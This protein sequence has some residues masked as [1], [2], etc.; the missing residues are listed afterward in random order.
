MKRAEKN[1]KKAARG[2][3]PCTQLSIH[4][5]CPGVTRSGE[6]IG[7]RDI[8]YSRNHR[9]PP[10]T[11]RVSFFR[12]RGRT[13]AL[14]AGWALTSAPAPTKIPGA[15]NASSQQALSCRRCRRRH[16][17]ELRTGREVRP[18]H[19]GAYVIRTCTRAHS[20]RT[21]ER[22]EQGGSRLAHSGDALA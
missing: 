14:R 19:T 7:T 13:I 21:S 2:H 5:C 15:T 10:R 8:T 12:A 11:H 4:V 22:R 1:K 20:G 16:R 3:E 17:H 6:E 9:H 18:A